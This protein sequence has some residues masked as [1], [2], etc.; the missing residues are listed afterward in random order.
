M[1][2]EQFRRMALRF[3][4]SSERSHMGHPDFRV[5]GKIFATLGY[6]EEGWAMVKLLPEQ[7]REFVK[8]EPGR[9]V[10][11]KGACLKAITMKKIERRW[12]Q[13]GEMSRQ[14]SC[15]ETR[16]VYLSQL[17]IRWIRPHL[18]VTQA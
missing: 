8:A 17:Y 12:M 6:P 7:Q 5:G 16:F 14:K 10:P 4:G 3:P 9:F 11:V 13:L 18:F 15:R 1:T 2:S